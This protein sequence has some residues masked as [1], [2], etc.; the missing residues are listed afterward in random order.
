MVQWVELAPPEESR[1]EVAAIFLQW[2]TP[3]QYWI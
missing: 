1:R 2:A 3:A